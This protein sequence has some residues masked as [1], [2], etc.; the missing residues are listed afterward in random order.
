MSKSPNT[1]AQQIA[2]LEEALTLP[3]PEATRAH[4]EQDLNDLRRQAENARAKI[5]GRTDVR[6]T[7]HGAAIGV[8]FGTVQTSF[9]TSPPTL[10]VQPA[11]VAAA[12]GINNQIE[13]LDAH[14]RTLAIY[15]KQQARLGSDFAP[16][17][18]EN[19]IHDA[20]VAI[21]HVKTTLRAWGAPVDDHPD[22]EAP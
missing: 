21:R 2:A 3:L 20:R 11:D 14:R 4:I 7:L 10:G 6:G 12:G 8:N 19:G 17:G 15:L 16:P 13:L 1:L 18:V 22:D 5:V 9:D